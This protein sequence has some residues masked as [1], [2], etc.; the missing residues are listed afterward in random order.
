MGT[1]IK[2]VINMEGLDADLDQIQNRLA[3]TPVSWCIRSTAICSFHIVF[4]LLCS[5][6]MVFFLVVGTYVFRGRFDPEDSPSVNLP[7]RQKPEKGTG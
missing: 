1:I 7:Q 3:F 6:C 4:A 2:F 5:L